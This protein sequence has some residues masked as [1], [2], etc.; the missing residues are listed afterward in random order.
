MAAAL[1]RLHRTHACG[2]GRRCQRLQA[3]VA[4]HAVSRAAVELSGR[5][6]PGRVYSDRGGGVIAGAATLE[7]VAPAAHAAT[8]G[9]KSDT[10]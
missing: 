4:R 1:P 2:T 3:F 8:V 10:R 7:Q 5:A 9:T 6:L